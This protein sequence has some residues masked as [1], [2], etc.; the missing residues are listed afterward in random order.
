MVLCSINF[1]VLLTCLVAQETSMEYAYSKYPGHTLFPINVQVEP[2][3]EG[4]YRE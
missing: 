3:G 4:Y 1:L 2:Y